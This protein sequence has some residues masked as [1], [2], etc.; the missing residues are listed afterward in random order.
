[1]QRVIRWLIWLPI[2]LA[3]ISFAIANRQQ[4]TLSLDP[5]TPSDPF[6][7]IQLPLWLLFFLGIL[8]GCIIGWI[9]CWFGQGKHRKRAR[10]VHAQFVKLQ[11]E[12]D[13]LISKVEPEPQQNIVP[14]GTGW[15]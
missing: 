3:V 7:S 10:D 11:Q 9:V 4:V 2:A 12:R 1:M 13:E 5:L 15:V 8:L 14:M 6:A